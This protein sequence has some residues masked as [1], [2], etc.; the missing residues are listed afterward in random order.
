MLD[1]AAGISRF[2]VAPAIGA[3]GY[4][5][6][7]SDRGAGVLISSI[8]ADALRRALAAVTRVVGGELMFRAGGR[9]VYYENA[10]ALVARARAARAH[11]MRWLAL[12]SLGREPNSFWARITTARQ[13]MGARHRS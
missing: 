8:A 6:P 11:G 3:F 10:G 9:V 5:W 4:S 2:R 12:F 13:T 7:V 1:Y